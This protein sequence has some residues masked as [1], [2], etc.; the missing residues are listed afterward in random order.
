MK[1]KINIYLF[2]FGLDVK[3]IQSYCIPTSCFHGLQIKSLSYQD[4]VFITCP[5]MI[6][7]PI[8]SGILF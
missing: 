6:L 5:F 4:S 1:A 7:S 3:Y 2:N 8:R